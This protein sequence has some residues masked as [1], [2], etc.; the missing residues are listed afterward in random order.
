[1]Q[2]GQATAVFAE[3]LAERGDGGAQAGDFAELNQDAALVNSEGIKIGL[4]FRLWAVRVVARSRGPP[5]GGTPNGSDVG[6][7]PVPA[8]ARCRPP[9]DLRRVGDSG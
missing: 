2:A 4:E 7:A 5:E 1:M 8:P 3:Q 6:E 9:F